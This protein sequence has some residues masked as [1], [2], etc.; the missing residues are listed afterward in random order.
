MIGNTEPAD[1]RAISAVVADDA[2]TL[3]DVVGCTSTP[4]A[5]LPEAAVLAASFLRHHP[6]SAFVIVVV[7]R[8]ALENESIDGARLLGLDDIGLSS[9]DAHRLPKIYRSRELCAAVKP[10]L[11]GTMLQSGAGTA[12]YFDPDVELFAGFDDVRAQAREHQVILNS[13]MSAVQAQP[14]EHDPGF[15]AI[16]RKAEPFLQWWREKLRE[17]FDQS[18]SVQQL[19]LDQVPASF[20]PN[21]LQDHGCGVGYWNLPGRELRRAGDHYTIDAVPVRSF[22]FSGGDVLHLSDSP[23]LTQMWSE[24][25]QK[26]LAAKREV[27]KRF[28]AG[29]GLL[30]SGLKIDRHMRRLYVRALARYKAAQGPEPPRPDGPGGEKSFLKWINQ[31]SNE[32]SPEIT[33]YMLAIHSS[34]SDLRAAFP[35]PVGKD[36]GAFHTWY[37]TFGNAEENPSRVL[38]P[39]DAPHGDVQHLAPEARNGS[40]PPAAV[41]VVGF[42]RAE[43]GIAESARLLVDA[44][45]AANIPVNTLSF[46]GTAN[47]Q[48]HPFEERAASAAAVDI[49]IVC[50]NADQLPCF[51]EKIGPE[52]SRGRYTIGVW[53]WEVDEFPETL[54]RAFDF[55]DEVWVATEFVR[56]TLLKVSPKPVFKFHLPVRVPETDRTLTRESLGLPERFCFLFTFDFL[57][58]FERKNPL[59]VIA[60]FK[61]AFAPGEGAALVLKSINGNHRVHALE[62]LRFA[63]TTHPDIQFSD[64]YMSA[65]E[66][67]TLAAECD[68]YVSLHRSE[69]FGLTMAEAMALG[70]PV[71]ATG[72]SGN[73]EFMT[74]ENSYLCGYTERLV[75]EDCDPYPA[76]ARWAEPDVIEAAA[77][78]RHVFDHRDEARARGERAAADMRL[79]HSPAVAAQTISERI[80]IIRHRR[81]AS[82]ALHRR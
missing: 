28:P 44:L 1:S 72:Y 45:H 14:F 42:F 43:L 63:A 6:G 15:I 68:C 26:V 4:A 17:N 47:R 9:E 50:V 36:A 64:G 7:D 41:N 56:Q 74:P 13:R 73:V 3:S 67:N 29:F 12:V 62:K 52:F 70:K 10:W 69:G 25:R 57:S 27:T 5:Q 19:L 34:R 59:A 58:V 53:F 51:A 20:R 30:P 82:A 35:E 60:A 54:H 22:Q 77:L 11:L 75:G 16:S 32:G 37:L 81:A 40:E 39:S 21:V 8:Y 24:H 31:R 65:I 66:K 2:P 46:D 79:L 55:V 76:S 80:R 18:R 33:R 38:L 78:M 61:R 49:N 71:I 23:A 48:A